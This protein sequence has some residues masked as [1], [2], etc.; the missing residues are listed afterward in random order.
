MLVN[1]RFNNYR[2]FY[3]EAVLSMEAVTDSELRTI[4]TF[5]IK[6]G[7]MPKG[8]TELLKSAVIFGANASGKS[9]VIKALAAMKN[10][11]IYSASQ[12]PILQNIEYFSFLKNAC[13]ED[14]LFEVEF[15]Q[16]DTY[17]K[18]GFTLNSSKVKEEWLYK[19]TERL[20]EV[21]SRKESQIS[22]MGL[23]KNATRLINLAPNA[24]FLSI[25]KERWKSL[26][27][28]ILASGI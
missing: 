16:N 24:L 19:R 9:N 23:G 28:P 6:E 1:F 3:K 10:I 20:T 4:N 5:T 14:T 25:E 11:I 2:S 13:E 8:E 18:Y 26:N 21:F 12:I 15:I 22:I 7:L 27:L 17:Y